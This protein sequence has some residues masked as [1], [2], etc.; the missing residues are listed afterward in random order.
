LGLDLTV[1][2]PLTVVK[3][4]GLDLT[5]VRPLTAVKPLTF[6]VKSSLA[7]RALRATRT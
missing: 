7:L 4:L 3:S 1:V 2:R 6:R 5:V